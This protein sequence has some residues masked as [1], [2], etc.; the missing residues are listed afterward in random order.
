PL[1][2]ARMVVRRLAAEGDDRH[3]VRAQARQQTTTDLPR[4]AKDHQ[5]H[6]APLCLRARAQSSR[7]QSTNRVSA[8]RWLPRGVTTLVRTRAMRAGNLCTDNASRCG[9][10]SSTARGTT[11][12]PTPAAA[13]ASSAW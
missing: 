13:A 2:P 8:G 3:L 12:Q 7:K 5:S 6:A 10:I 9:Y 11:Q 4:T 1:Y